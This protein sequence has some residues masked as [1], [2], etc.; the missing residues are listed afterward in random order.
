MQKSR[1]RL[2]AILA[3]TLTLVI[4][5][6]PGSFIEYMTYRLSD[7]LRW[8]SSSPDPG[9]FPIDKLVHAGLFLIC[10]FLLTLGWLHQVKSW[11]PLLI[12]LIA[13]AA[14]TEI[15]QYFIPGR[16]ASAADVIADAI[17]AVVG[18]LLALMYRGR[19]EKNTNSQG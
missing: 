15:L 8:P 19:K 9:S 5:V 1:Y 4:L 11:L 7:W 17:G 10:G 12:L 13:Y 14:V 6:L 3:L 2:L 18:I 16:G